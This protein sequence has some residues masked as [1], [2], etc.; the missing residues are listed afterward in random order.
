MIKH[1]HTVYYTVVLSRAINWFWKPCTLHTFLPLTFPYLCVHVHMCIC[2]CTCVLVCMWACIQLSAQKPNQRWKPEGHFIKWE[3]PLFP[4]PP[5]PPPQKKKQ[6]RPLPN[7][8]HWRNRWW[9]TSIWEAACPPLPDRE[10]PHR[11]RKAANQGVGAYCKGAYTAL[12]FPAPRGGG[13]GEPGSPRGPKSELQHCQEFT[14]G[15]VLLKIKRFSEVWQS[16][17]FGFLLRK[18]LPAKLLP[19]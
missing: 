9:Q 5:P 8:R 15:P 13:G 6:F 7:F 10:A 4:E 19:D 2:M 14:A 17:S 11:Q 16:H 1:S 18:P 12:L 3:Q